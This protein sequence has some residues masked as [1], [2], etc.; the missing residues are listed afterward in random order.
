MDDLTRIERNYGCYAEYA[1][2]R[3]EDEAYEYEQQAKRNE[4]C[5]ANKVKL[6][7]AGNR[8]MYFC[9]DCFDCKHYE[10]VGPTSWD[11]WGQDDVTHGICHHKELQDIIEPFC[12]GKEVIEK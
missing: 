12:K 3:E 4:Y 7:S 2:Q 6:E 5:K 11:D 8:A 1:R 9:E 10:D